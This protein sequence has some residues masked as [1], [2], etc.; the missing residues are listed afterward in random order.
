MHYQAYKLC[1][2]TFQDE[3]PVKREAIW[4]ISN[5]LEI[6]SSE[7]IR[8]AIDSDMLRIFAKNVPKYTYTTEIFD[9]PMLFHLLN[10]I[11]NMIKVRRPLLYIRKENPKGRFEMLF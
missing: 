1:I 4:C 2:F 7:Q 11:R 10:G 5:L 3:G 8:D 6:G 9:K